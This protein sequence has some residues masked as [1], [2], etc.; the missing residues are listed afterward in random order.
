MTPQAHGTFEVKLNPQA[1]ATLEEPGIGRLLLDKQFSGD[2]EAV[3]AGQMLSFQAATEPSAGYV[4]MELVSG[5]LHGRPGSFVLQHSGTLARGVPGLS[6]QVVPDSG[7][8]ELAGLSGEMALDQRGGG[9]AY[10]LTYTLPGAEQ[11]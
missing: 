5:R 8:G 7:T 3:S 10:T 1:P 2:L 11:G 6:I 4:A 9:H